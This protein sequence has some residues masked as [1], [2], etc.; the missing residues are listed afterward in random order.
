MGFGPV[1]DDVG[2][3]GQLLGSGCLP[4]VLIGQLAQGCERSASSA[5]QGVQDGATGGAARAS[6]AQDL[7]CDHGWSRPI[8]LTQDVAAIRGPA[9]PQW[10]RHSCGGGRAV[11]ACSSS[12]PVEPAAG[13][14]WRVKVLSMS[15]YPLQYE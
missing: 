11:A 12:R 1:L 3:A 13:R 8:G 2:R 15:R 7:R 6:L 5:H 9:N 10:L 14:D 4:V